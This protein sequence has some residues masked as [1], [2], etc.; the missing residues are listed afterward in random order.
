MRRVQ[1][2][3][4]PLF[5]YVHIL[6]LVSSTLFLPNLHLTF[7]TEQATPICVTHTLPGFGAGA[8]ITPRKRLALVAQITLPAIMTPTE[9]EMGY[10]RQE[11]RERH[12]QKQ[13][14]TKYGMHQRSVGCYISETWADSLA[15]S[16]QI[17]GT[18]LHVTSLLTHR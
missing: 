7:V 13:A 1:K 4:L 10:N 6:Q 14:D 18:V 8:M 5:K 16:G 3:A 12:K 9:I 17:A 15:I 11:V 2:L